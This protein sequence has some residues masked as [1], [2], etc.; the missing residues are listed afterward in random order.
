MTGQGVLRASFDS[1]ALLAVTQ[2]L[3]LAAKTGAAPLLIDA[4][5][6]G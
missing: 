1:W 2:W 3:A 4:I 5:G 6:R